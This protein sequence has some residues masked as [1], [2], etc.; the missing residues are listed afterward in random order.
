MKKIIIFLFCAFFISTVFSQ[1]SLASTFNPNLILTDEELTNY[2]SLNL[3]Q[4]KD[5]L[6][7]KGGTLAN[8]LDTEAHMF[9][10]QI[11]YDASQLYQINPKYALVLLQKEQSLITDKTPVQGQYDWATGY[12]ACDGCN[13]TDPA[14]QKYKGDRKS[15]V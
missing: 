15:V 2:Q 12:G 3:A 13:G 11:I 8:Y 1:S 5:F 14:L 10:H 9:A 7:K 6:V 4:I